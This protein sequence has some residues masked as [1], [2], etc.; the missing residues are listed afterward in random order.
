MT[1]VEPVFS[2]DATTM[3]AVEPQTVVVRCRHRAVGEP[4]HL[5][6]GIGRRNVGRSILAAHKI[7]VCKKCHAEIH[8]HVLKI[9]CGDARRYDARTVYYERVE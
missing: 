3:K 2:F 8:G 1:V 9:A 5:I 6:S 4:H 7:A